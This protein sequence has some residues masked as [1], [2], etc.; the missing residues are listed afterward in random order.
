VTTLDTALSEIKAAAYAIRILAET[1]NN[2]PESLLK[3]R[4]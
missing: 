4:R 2:Q 3:G 1:I